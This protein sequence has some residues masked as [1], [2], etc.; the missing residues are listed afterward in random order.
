[1]PL[2]KAHRQPGEGQARRLPVRDG[3]P[4]AQDGRGS[5]S[6]RRLTCT[7]G[8]CHCHDDP[9]Q[10]HGPYGYWTR[11]VAGKTVSKVLSAEQAEEYQVLIDNDRRLRSLVQELERV[12][13]SILGVDPRTPR[14]R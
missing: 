5:L 7:H 2:T 8:G 6:E 4:P 11:R 14:R 13:V 1:M 3:R 10:L 9:P 12:G